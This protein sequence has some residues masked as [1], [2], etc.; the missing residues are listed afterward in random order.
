[1]YKYAN[2]Y[3]G[4]KRNYTAIKT[5]FLLNVNISG[6]KSNLVWHVCHPLYPFLTPD[7]NQMQT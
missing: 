4:F 2:A 1:M 6:I 3:Q 7:A 5:F